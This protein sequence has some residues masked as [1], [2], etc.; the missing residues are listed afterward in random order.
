MTYTNCAKDGTGGLSWAD[1][2]FL[3]RRFVPEVG[4]VLAPLAGAS[5]YNAVA[6]SSTDYLDQVVSQSVADSVLLESYHHGRPVYEAVL[7]WYR[8]EAARLSRPLSFKTWTMT[9]K[10][11]LPAYSSSE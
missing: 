1:V 8:R 5:L 7:A 10:D 3:K 6:W 9:H 2:T 11:R 4:R